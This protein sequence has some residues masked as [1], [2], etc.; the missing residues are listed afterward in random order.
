MFRQ[1]S[2]LSLISPNTSA[3]S[4]PAWRLPNIETTSELR[5]A[6]FILFKRMNDV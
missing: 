5:K 4:I 6:Y 2:F 3:K 1:V